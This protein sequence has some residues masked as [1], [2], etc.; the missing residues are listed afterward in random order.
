MFMKTKSVTRISDKY[1]GRQIIEF[2]GKF[3]S[4]SGPAAK[5]TFGNSYD[6]DENNKLKKRHVGNTYDV[7]EK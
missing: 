3:T 5:K 6:V 4:A 2:K 7:D 1:T